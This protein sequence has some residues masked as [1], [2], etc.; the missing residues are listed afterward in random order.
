VS[1]TY[2]AALARVDPNLFTFRCFCIALAPVARVAKLFRLRKLVT[3]PRAPIALV[4]L[5]AVVTRFYQL[6][7]ESFWLDEAITFH[8]SKLPIRE[9]IA[10]ASRTFH[11]PAYFMA[12]HYWMKLGDDE[13]ML[14]VPSACL[15]VFTVLFA[16]GIGR[17]VA[18][19]WAG[20]AAALVLC[21]NPKAVEYDQEARM[22]APYSLGAAAAIY[23]I[24]WLF[25]HPA[26]AAVPVWRLVKDR[27]ARAAHTPL[28][29]AWS[30]IVVGEIVALYC[31]ATAVLFFV[32]CSIV[33]LLFVAFR[34]ERKGFAFNWIVVNAVVLLVFLPWLPSLFSQSQDIVSRGFWITEPTFGRAVHTVR[35]VVLFGGWRFPWLSWIVLAWALLGCFALRK[36]P[37]TLAVL[38]SFTL[39]G[40]GLLLLASLRQPIFMS[41]LFLWT[42]IPAAVVVGAGLT[43]WKRPAVRAACLLAFFGVG[44]FSLYR[45][46]YVASTKPRWHEAVE[47][48]SNVAAPNVKILAIAR[49]EQRLLQYYLERRT[50]PVP[51]FEYE[52]LNDTSDAALDRAIAGADTVFTVQGH[53]APMATEIRAKLE[54]RGGR[55]DQHKGF[56]IGVAIES[57]DMTVNERQRDGRKKDKPTRAGRSAD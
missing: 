8:R 20:F 50:D 9:L 33:A 37:L 49:R 47:L 3:H 56:G 52:A 16:H 26:D 43:L 21:L 14:R 12:M 18:G 40:P 10:D 1:L 23:G 17:L 44:A 7:A 38:L 41:R 39:L 34:P 55:R 48:L 32:A 53:S 2:H 31:H 24:V 19:N 42:T 46:Y 27:A 15:G 51:A 25:S 28:V 13:L 35:E 11:N 57:Y 30:A 54:A 29:R 4:V 36:K 45:G 5:L 22:Y 6:G